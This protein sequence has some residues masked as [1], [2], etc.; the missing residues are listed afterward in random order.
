M[1]GDIFPVHPQDEREHSFSWGTFLLDLCPIHVSGRVTS[2]LVVGRRYHSREADHQPSQ[3]SSG[4]IQYAIRR[5]Q[6]ERYPSPWIR[7]FWMDWIG[8]VLFLPVRMLLLLQKLLVKPILYPSFYLWYRNWIQTPH[9]RRLLRKVQE[10]EGVQA[11]GKIVQHPPTRHSNYFLVLDSTPESVK[12][13]I[14][15][16]SQERTYPMDPQAIHVG[17]Y[18]FCNSRQEVRLYYCA[19]LSIQTSRLTRRMH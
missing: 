16:M 17:E 18:E 15:T 9:D 6:S 19:T 12:D 7:F 8:Y 5:F 11:T 3:R 1:G 2:P 10:E 14:M 4:H 13:W